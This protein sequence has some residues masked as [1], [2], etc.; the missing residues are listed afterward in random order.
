[1]LKLSNVINSAL[2]GT[3]NWVKMAAKSATSARF[4]GQNLE[5]III[6]G[7]K[8][9]RFGKA[10]RCDAMLPSMPNILVYLSH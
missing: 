10:E 9:H 1:M 3:V 5:L 4:E 2:C 8:T 6:L 7:T